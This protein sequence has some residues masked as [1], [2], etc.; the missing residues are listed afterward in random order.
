MAWIPPAG[1]RPTLTVETSPNNAQYWFFFERAL[2]PKRAQRLG[3]GLR[4]V[5]G[6]DSDT[7]NPCQP[8]RIPGT[9]NYPNKM[10][11]RPWAGRH[12]DLVSGSDA[13][14]VDL[15]QFKIWTVEEFEL[16]FP[17]L[18]SPA[19][20][21]GRGTG[22]QGGGSSTRAGVDDVDEAD[23]AT[24]SWNGFMMAFPRGKTARWFSSG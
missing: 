20:P 21:N 14:T 2:S 12:A 18:L 15:S 13:M 3:E 4:R 17:P 8:Y 7:G 6:G 5:T 24:T 9:V 11:G 19:K 10:Q 22:A 23:L 1:V 16:A